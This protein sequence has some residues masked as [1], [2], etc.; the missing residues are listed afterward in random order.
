MGPRCST[1][2]D[3]A[4]ARRE[5]HPFQITSAV[6]SRLETRTRVHGAAAVFLFDM[7]HLDGQ[8]LLDRPGAERQAALAAV[9]PALP[10]RVW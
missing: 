3:R 7:L 2:S 1:G 5:P 10:C 4:A 6:G 8:D 9:V